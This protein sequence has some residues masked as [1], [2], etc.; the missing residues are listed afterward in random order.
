MNVNKSRLETR[1]VHAGTRS[2][3]IEGA[4]VTPIFQSTV[5]ESPA[6]IDNYDD[7]VYPRLNN[8]P[9]HDVVGKRIASLEGAESG[10]VFASGMAAISTALVAVLGKGGHAL[11]QD[12]L[13]GG[14]R[15]LLTTYFGD[16]G[17]DFDFIDGDDPDSWRGKLQTNTRTIFTETIANPLLQVADHRAIVAFAREHGLVSMVDNTFATPVNFLPIELGYDLSLHSCTKYLNGHSDITAGAVVGSDTQVRRVRSLLN[18]LGGS[19]DAHACFLLD[20]GI[21]TLVVRVREQCRNAL[22]LARHLEGHRAVSR[23]HYPGLESHSHHQRAVDLFPDFGGVLAIELAG[24][25][26]AAA[27]LIER[28]T[29]P[30]S[31]PSLG[32]VETLITRPVVTSHSGLTAIE[33]ER[34]GITDGLLRVSL[35]IEAVEDII[36]DFEQALV[37]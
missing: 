12:Q 30:T 22:T 18:H 29:I 2:P 6:S 24:G 1:A 11:V 25:A 23:V 19:L 37:S 9:N 3:R 32:G 31:G 13:Y 17:L 10:L 28:L 4:L 34:L 16:W 35:G 20:R 36:D 7:I 33:R 14:T 26:D 8:L 27:Q 5:F 21:K 15:T